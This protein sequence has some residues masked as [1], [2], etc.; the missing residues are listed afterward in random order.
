MNGESGDAQTP[1]IPDPRIPGLAAAGEPNILALAA[2]IQELNEWTASEYAPVVEDILRSF[3]PR[4]KSRKP[5]PVSNAWVEW[6][7][8]DAAWVV[9]ARERLQSL[10]W[11]MKN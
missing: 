4:D 9:K 6:R 2:R 3:P 10:S 7:L 11:F 8:N 1:P 5:L